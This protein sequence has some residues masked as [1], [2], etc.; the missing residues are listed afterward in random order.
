MHVRPYSPALPAHID[1]PKCGNV[2]IL[3]AIVLRVEP[4]NQNVALEWG[5]GHAALQE[6]AHKTSMNQISSDSVKSL[7][8]YFDQDKP[9]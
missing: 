4:R 7:E 9:F 2:G 3:D 8:D 6:E 1:C 5:G